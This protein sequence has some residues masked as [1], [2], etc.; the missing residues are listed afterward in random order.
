MR[1]F[2]HALTLIAS[3]ALLGTACASDKAT[4]LPAGPTEAPS[5]AVCDGTI[6]MNDE[7]KF[8]PENCTIK[9]GTTVTWTTVGSAP[10]TSTS[11]PTAPVEFD[12]EQVASGG[13]FDFT[14]ETAGEVPYYC[15]LHASAGARAGMIGTIVVEA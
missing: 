12:S 9:V 8:V 4:G 3:L 11:E 2:A 6:E 14:F 7:L 5:A 1:R 10:H 13:S 15:K